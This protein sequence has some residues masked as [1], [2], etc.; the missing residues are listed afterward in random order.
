MGNIFDRNNDNSEF[1]EPLNVE[2]IYLDRN[3]ELIEVS[4]KC[5][6]VILPLAQ[7]NPRKVYTIVK[8]SESGKTIIS[9]SGLDTIDGD[10]KINITLTKQY[11]KFK[12]ISNGI[13]RWYL[14]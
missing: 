9:R 10:D 12:I 3:H 11:S 4:N 2:R 8:T 6:I 7:E 1:N 5:S 13:S 14:L